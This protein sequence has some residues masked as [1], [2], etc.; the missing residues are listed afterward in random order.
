MNAAIM[1]LAHYY[2]RRDV[3]EDIRRKKGSSALRTLAASDISMLG[4]A[5]LDAHPKLIDKAAETVRNDPK[6]RTLAE[7]YERERRRIQR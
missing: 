3:K 7:R 1:T 4:K 5:W 6:L 2:A